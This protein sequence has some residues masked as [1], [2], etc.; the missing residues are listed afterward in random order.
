MNNKSITT[1]PIFD[2]KQYIRMGI[3]LLFVFV[4]GLGYWMAFSQ[5]DSAA[6]APGIVTVE[7]Q[8]KTIE[9]LEGGIVAE[10]LVEDGDVVAKGQPLI[11]L[12]AVAARTRFIQLNL[13]YYSLLAQ[14]QRLH[15]ERNG[16]KALSFSDDL[17][18]NLQKY[19]S[20]EAA[21]ETQK[22]LF[23]ARYN[24]KENELA[25]IS[26]KLLS[27]SSDKE[28]YVEKIKQEEVAIY[29]LAKEAKVHEKLLASGYSSQLKT[30]EFKRTQ[31]KYASSLIELK[32]RLQNS[33]LEELQVIKQKD[34][35]VY[36][37]IRDIE[38]ELQE[39]SKVKDDTLELLIH[40]QD[41]LSR[42][43]IKSPNAGQIVGLTVFNTGD[44]ISPGE[45]LLEVVPFN[46]RLII[47]AKLKPEDIDVIKVGQS[48]MV[49]LSAYSFRS[50]PLVSGIVIH[51]AADR[52]LNENTGAGNE[53]FTIKVS[54]E[55]SV[56]E[57]LVGVELHPGM[58]AEVFI[59]LKSR[60]PLD[61]LL[62]PL[63][64]DLFR[65]FRES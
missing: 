6:I 3:L 30:F 65:A 38:A 59:N 55:K 1:A 57:S 53:G 63:S 31:A 58:A 40:A 52:L 51:V 21:L 26:A 23:K 48:A 54:I 22:R 4:G 2:E 20:L 64:L 35:T 49:R 62:G 16:E 7:G 29:Y 47:V 42:V 56:L 43:V 13:I 37:Y 28:M 44:V 10:V 9:H 8:R 34:V 33:N 12:S 24:L 36:R 32:G 41:V 60:T 17:L 18:N 15:H 14:E 61:Y 11:T 39:V 50:T 46:E 5:L 19:P 25:S 27:I 45:T